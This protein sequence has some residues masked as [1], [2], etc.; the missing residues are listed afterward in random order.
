MRIF[1]ST[2]VRA[3][4]PW[5]RCL[6]SRFSLTLLLAAGGT[7]APALWARQSA[8][9]QAP[10][11]P[12]QT[13]TAAQLQQ[14]VAPLA[15]YPDGL[16]AQTLTAATFPEQVV[17]ADRWVQAHP[18]LRGDALGQAVDRQSWDPSV[19]ALTAF[20]TVLGSMDKNLSWT[21]ALG[22]AYYN[23]PQD[24]MDAV[25]VMR[26]RAEAAGTLRTT[27]QQ[28][29]AAQGQTITIQPQDP[30][31]VYVPAYDPWADYGQPVAAWPGWYGYP[32]IWFGGPNLSF[33]VGFGI[34]FFGGFA[35]GWPHWGF[36]WQNRSVMYNHN[37]YRSR[38]NTFYNRGQFYRGGAANR[39][40]GGDRGG[41]SNRPQGGD[42]GAARAS[43]AP[44]A[45]R[46]YEDAH[47]QGGEHS[48][49]FGGYQHGGEA[50]GFSA[51]GSSSMGHAFGHGGGGRRF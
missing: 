4:L 30:D 49:A 39:P 23:Q 34:G 36:D 20:P 15:L 35:W 13:Q 51:R 2:T 21:S 32:G 14:T 50:R 33:G 19:K 31:M 10:A 37:Q 1:Q 25:Q 40:Q 7:L 45:G 11:Q 24:V 28:T 41:V 29:V 3:T 46:G 12:Y 8:P 42:R 27:P 26:R 48:G 17:E 44:R 9:V 18:E 47:A 5:P 16:V 38:S 6:V 43:E 22:D